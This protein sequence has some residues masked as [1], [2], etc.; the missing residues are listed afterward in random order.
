MFDVKT[1]PEG[2]TVNI[3]YDTPVK[4]Q[5]TRVVVQG[6]C[7]YELAKT[8][9]DVAVI[10]NNIYSTLKQQPDP[11]YRKYSYIMFV[12]ADGKLRCAADAWINNIK[13]IKNI[14]VNFT[15]TL[16]N[17]DEIDLLTK[18]LAVVGLNNVKYEIVEN[19]AT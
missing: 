4:G 5:E 1:I 12:G 15:V 3:V 14:T 7:G 13:I 16:D 18:Q 17:K 8:I 19:E 2:S 11:N 9:E 10:H 6:T